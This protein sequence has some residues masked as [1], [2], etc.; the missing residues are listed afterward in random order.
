MNLGKFSPRRG[1]Y[2][3]GGSCVRAC[4]RAVQAAGPVSAKGQGVQSVWGQ[5]QSN[6][7]KKR[8]GLDHDRGKECGF[9][10]EGQWE[11][12]GE[13]E[14]GQWLDLIYALE[15][16]P[17]AAWYGLKGRGDGKGGAEPA[18]VG[19]WEDVAW[20]ELQGWREWEIVILRISSEVELTERPPSRLKGDLRER[21]DSRMSPWF[22]SKQLDKWWCHDW[23]G[24]GL[25]RDLGRLSVCW[26]WPW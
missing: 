26:L 22:Q 19:Q 18:A 15:Y 9:Y 23:G 14:A 24:E 12:M 5:G 7:K 6:M 11:A 2:Q 3:E 16:I 4:G 17:L 21:E 8:V 1:N 13:F 25:S 20:T 10:P